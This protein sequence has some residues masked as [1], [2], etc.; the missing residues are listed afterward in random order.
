MVSALDVVAVC[1]FDAGGDDEHATTPL[2]TRMV[3]RDPLARS[4]RWRTDEFMVLI[5]SSATMGR[6]PKPHPAEFDVF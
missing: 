6:A 2:T 5:P 4:V 1:S 3:A